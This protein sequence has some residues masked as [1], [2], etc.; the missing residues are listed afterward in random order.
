[1][2]ALCVLL[3]VAC[4]YDYREKRIPNYLIAVMTLLGVGWRFCRDGTGGIIFYLAGAFF[5]MSLLYPFFKIGTVGAGDVKLFGVAAG[6]L[7]FQKIFLFLFVSLLIAAI[8]SI[9]KLI[10]KRRKKYGERHP[11]KICLS[12]PVLISVLLCLGGVY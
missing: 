4:G 3:T 2:A 12:G 8:F 9:F 7:P 11:L 6:F 5:I 1:M 10:V